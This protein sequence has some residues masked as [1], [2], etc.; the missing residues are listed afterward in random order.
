MIWYSSYYWLSLLIIMPRMLAL[1]IRFLSLI[2]DIIFGFL[3]KKTLI[4]TQN[5]NP[6]KNYS[7]NFKIW[8]LSASKTSTTHKNIKPQNY[9]LGNKVWLSSKHLK[10]KQNCKLEAKFFNLFQVLNL[11]GKQTYK[12]ELPKKLKIHNVSYISLLKQDITKTTQVNE[13]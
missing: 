4:S 12:L 13:I 9:A 8:W 11:R 1:A 2:A 3:I 10:I 7:P 6:Q 5:W